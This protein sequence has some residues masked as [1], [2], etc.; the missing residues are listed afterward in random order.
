MISCVHHLVGAAEIQRML[1]VSR[2]RVTQLTQRPDFPEPTV[3]LARGAVWHTEDIV[4]WAEADGR[5]VRE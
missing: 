1:G 2:Q 3:V 5:E 4:A